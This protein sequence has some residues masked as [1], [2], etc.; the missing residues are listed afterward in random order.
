MKRLLPLLLASLIFGHTPPVSA[1]I[2]Q[3]L[4]YQGRVTVQGVNFN[5]TGQF[6]FA[7]VD[8]GVNLNQTATAVAMAAGS[9]TF[10]FVQNGGSGYPEPPVVTIAPPETPGGVQATAQAI[11]GQGAGS[12]TGPTDGVHQIQ[13]TD[14]GSGYTSQPV[15]TIAP[16]PPNILNST[17]WSNAGD[18]APGEVP[19]TAIAL[20]VTNGL[21]SVQ[22][23][24]VGMAPFN[25][26]I[27]YTPLYLRVWF[28]DGVHGFQQL[29]PDQPLSAAPYALQAR[30]AE[31]VPPGSIGAFQLANGAVSALKLA[32]GAV[33]AAKL[34]P[35]AIAS[36]N[37]DTGGTAPTAGKVLGFTA[38]GLRWVAGGGLTLPF[39]GTGTNIGN[40]LFQINA[41]QSY[42][43]IW[44][45][46][47]G[48]AV[49][50]R[51]TGGTG[52]LGEATAAE[53]YGVRGTAY[54]ANGHGVRAASDLGDGVNA[55]TY[56]T[57]K[58]GVFG[59]ATGADSAGVHGAS[60]LHHGVY[61]Y[62]GSADRPA[63][64]ANAPN[65]AEA[66]HG[67]SELNYGVVGYSRGNNKYGVWGYTDSVISGG[68][69]FAHYNGGFALSTFGK[70][71]IGG[72][73]TI[74]GN[75]TAS[76]DVIANGA[77]NQ[78]AYL[79]GNGDGDVEFGSKNAAVTTAAF[80]N[81]A[82]GKFLNTIMRD[83]SVRV[84]TIYGGADLAEPFD[85]GG[86]ELPKG[87][88]VAIDP[89]TPGKLRVAASEYDTC[90]A[91]IISGANGINPGLTLHQEGVHQGGQHV[92]L[93]G[94]VY[95][96]ADAS[97]GAIRP[98]DLL[99]TSRTPGH[100]MKAADATR[101][102]GAILGKSMS[103]L[104]SGTGYVLVLVTLQ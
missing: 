6:K 82:S 46:S 48:S 77:G 104:D 41:L 33:S 18:L 93:T 7:L 76:G 5:G 72:N 40:A 26:D 20:P 39:N 78:Q 3:H 8:A 65:G 100:A 53:G 80:W 2:P 85:T 44:G 13:I 55:V 14:A 22:L 91:G 37:F 81:P 64:W 102:Q 35:G 98:G 31:S 27:F 9:V 54:G 68:G 60:A 67:H 97:H 95:C 11:M 23:G 58:S 103:S 19:G 73:L 49:V 71:D 61:A 50:G 30:L 57:G 83:A 99:T 38:D 21:Y 43:A 16:P 29:T 25:P 70:A 28:D 69:H 45:E 34:A 74:S 94:R 32:D 17:Y 79:G 12:G 56:A 66:I 89:E 90:V 101:S 47:T 92:A 15:V 24:G 42:P 96:R 52:V 10:I 86:A 36:T 59:N 75:A 63:I 88:V 1:Q 84:L 87:S 4:S 62:T 51:T